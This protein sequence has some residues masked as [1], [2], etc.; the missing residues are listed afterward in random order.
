[1][2]NFVERRVLFWDETRKG[3]FRWNEETLSFSTK[4]ESD[5]WNLATDPFA[6]VISILVSASAVTP[7]A[8]LVY[9][10]IGPYK[11]GLLTRF[12]ASSAKDREHAKKFGFSDDKCDVCLRV[13]QGGTTTTYLLRSKLNPSAD[14]LKGGSYVT[15]AINLP[16]KDGKVTKVD[17]LHAP[18][19]ISKGVPTDAK[20]LYRWRAK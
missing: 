13:T 18:D 11:A 17:L 4:L 8:N 12:D 20:V 3:Y 19:V 15:T 10:P 1:M 5:G 16:A 9:P 2:Q 14:P 7:E 6:E